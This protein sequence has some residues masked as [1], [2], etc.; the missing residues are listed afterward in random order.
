M[1][2]EFNGTTL[3][4]GI[5]AITEDDQ[6]LSLTI[7]LMG[8]NTVSGSYGIYVSGEDNSDLIITGS[9]SLA[10]EGPGNGYGTGIEVSSSIGYANLTI[11]EAEV[12]TANGSMRG[13][14]FR[15]GTNHS[16]ATLT[17][18]G[19]KLT[20]SA[21][22]GITYQIGSNG[23]DGSWPDRHRTML[24]WMCRLV[25]FRL[26]LLLL[27]KLEQVE[28]APAESSLTTKAGTVYGNVTLKEDLTIGEARA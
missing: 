2:G 18:N 16:N 23:G 22:Y 15:S 1:G 11:N 21:K 20:V 6:A 28:Q 8:T 13:I 24:W 25:F 26:N 27:F 7:D 4:A 5:C 12:S 3:G 17:V 9:G 10:A 14:R 19:G